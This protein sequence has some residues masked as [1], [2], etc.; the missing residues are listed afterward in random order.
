[1]ANDRTDFEPEVRSSA[2][3]S[4]DSRMAANGKANEAILTKL[5][6][7]EREDLSDVEAVQMG[8]HLQPVI[9]RLVSNRLGIEIRDADYAMSH[10]REPWLRSHFDFISTD[11][12]TLV[13]TKNYNAAVRNHF[14]ADA[15]LVPPADLIQC[16][17]EATVH[18]VDHVILAVLFGGQELVTV[19]FTFTEA[20][21]TD[22]IQEMAGYWAH[23][24][25][26]TPLP[27]ETPEQ[28]RA[29]FP[30]DDGQVAIA[31]RQVEDLALAVR[32]TK[33]QLKA[34]EEQEKMMSAALQQFIGNRATLATIDGRVLA[35]WKNAKGSMQ[36][37]KKSF[38]L[39]M[40]DIYR[41]FVRE[42]PGS[43]RFLV[44]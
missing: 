16:L 23:V 24:V 30:K 25:T 41:Q 2:W 22:L 3:W 15:R 36:F 32:Q 18:N 35:T 6:M 4:G 27:A 19:D 43:R 10:V 12:Q 7:L 37:D 29:I 13:E 1:M 38:E 17:H 42:V 33:D 11:G 26:K 8:H 39:S 21:K 9:G 28:A 44:K 31:T 34:L 5:G 40:P 14:D 20:Q